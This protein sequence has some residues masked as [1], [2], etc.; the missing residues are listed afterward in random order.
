MQVRQLYGGLQEA[1]V[2]SSPSGRQHCVHLYN[3]SEPGTPLSPSSNRVNQGI[4][5][6]SDSG[7]ESGSGSGPESGSYGYSP[8][9]GYPG[10]GMHG[11][12]YGG[13]EGAS[14]S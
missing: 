6:G 10:G 13:V 8:S 9:R 2:A 4:D 3:K 14:T 11:G 7:S 12:P 5:S 1:I